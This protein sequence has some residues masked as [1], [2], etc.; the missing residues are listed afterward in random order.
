M[1]SLMRVILVFTLFTGACFAQSSQDPKQ[2]I[3]SFFEAFHKQDSTRLKSLVTADI[4]MQSIG[5]DTEGKAKVTTTD[6]NQF[7]KSIANIPKDQTFREELLDYLIQID[8]PM[9]HVWTPY[10][11][12]YNGNFSHCGVNSFQLVKEETGWKIMYLVDTR[13]REGCTKP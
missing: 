8:G 12:W 9:A 4:R 10:E 11:F 6:F 1:K 13:R 2:T 7:V 3:I 5:Q